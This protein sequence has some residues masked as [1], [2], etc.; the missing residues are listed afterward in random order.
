M[1][2]PLCS[3]FPCNYKE[4]RGVFS[5]FS[6]KPEVIP[7]FPLVVKKS[8]EGSPLYGAFHLG[9][10]LPFLFP[11]LR[12]AFCSSLLVPHTFVSFFKCIHFRPGQGFLEALLCTRIGIIMVHEIAAAVENFP[13]FLSPFLALHGLN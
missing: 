11:S 5:I 12:V 4:N 2:H 10:S 9:I 8:K 7:V 6:S 3:F 1:H 13:S